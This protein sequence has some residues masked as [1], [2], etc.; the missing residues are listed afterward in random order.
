MPEEFQNPA[1]PDEVIAWRKTLREELLRRIKEEDGTFLNTTSWDVHPLEVVLKSE[2]ILEILTKTTAEAASSPQHPQ[3]SESSEHELIGDDDDIEQLQE[4]HQL[5]EKLEVQ[6]TWHTGDSTKDNQ[7]EG[8][9]D[10]LRLLLHDGTEFQVPKEVGTLLAELI[11]RGRSMEEQLAHHQRQAA[12]STRMADNRPGQKGHFEDAF[13]IPDE[14]EVWT[15]P[16]LLPQPARPGE[17]AGLRE[18]NPAWVGGDSHN[19]ARSAI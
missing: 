5:D 18:V 15:G 13:S 11:A 19:P 7:R 12:S 4:T 14:R 1:S 3:H 16:S 2:T 6:E 10:M 17:Q 9:R 8:T